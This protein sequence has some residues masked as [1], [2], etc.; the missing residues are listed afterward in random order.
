MKAKYKI[1]FVAGIVLVVVSAALRLR[2]P[3][4]AHRSNKST[5]LEDLVVAQNQIPPVVNT[6]LPSNPSGVGTHKL[7]YEEMGILEKN[8]FLTEVEKQ[9]LPVIFKLMI[10]AKRLEHASM[11]QLHLQTVLSDAMRIK[12]PTPEFLEQL[13]AFITNSANSEFERQL[14]IGALVDAATKESVNLLLQVANSATDKKIK[15]SA[16]TLTGNRGGPAL[17]PMLERTWLETTNPT[18]L[19]S[20]AE[21]M[22][23]ISAPSGIELLL[24]AALAKNSKDQARQEAATRALS[25]VLIYK[26]DAVP[27]LAA[28]LKDQTP[29]SEAAQLVAPILAATSGPDGQKALVEWLQSRPENAAPLVEQLFRQNIRTDPFEYAWAA[30]LDPALPFK[31]EENRNAIRKALEAY[32]AS[33][34]R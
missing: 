19:W 15:D 31:N 9:D 14:V 20:T 27:P 2:K 32:R 29:T 13:Y 7:K 3:P 22:A 26:E 5:P 18:L 33:R 10:D 34:P 25:I 12:K 8:A 24:S 28:R 11:K 6:P 21:S 16:A 17:S 4:P 30:A 23:E 1:L